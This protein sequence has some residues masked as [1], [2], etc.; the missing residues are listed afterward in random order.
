M[1][2]A[3]EKKGE[4]ALASADLVNGHGE[5]TD[6]LGHD[7]VRPPRLSLAQAMSPQLKKTDPKYIQGLSEGQ[8][9]ND[10]TT[11]NYGE[12]PI[13][14]VVIMFLGKRAMEFAPMDEGG[15]IVDFDVPLNDPR[16]A[17]TTGANGERVKPVATT[18]YDYLVWLPETS[19]VC[20]LSMKNTQLKVAKSLN[21]LLKLPLKIGD[22]IVAQPPAWARTFLLGTAAESKDKYTWANFTLRP[23]GITDEAVRETA[24]SLYAAYAEK[25]VV[26]E[27]DTDAAEESDEETPF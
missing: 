4:T 1:T 9:Y 19:E 18:F 5:G 24:A 25:N 22:Q 20:A 23:K 26:I 7:D 11:E 8:L 3:I 10:L 6:G 13:E 15:G 17:F 12:G 2:K 27:R 14:M 16:C 21:S